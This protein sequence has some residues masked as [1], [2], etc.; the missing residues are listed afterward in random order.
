M[1]IWKEKKSLLVGLGDDKKRSFVKRKTAIILP[2]DAGE[3]HSDFTEELQPS[4]LQMT[5]FSSLL[6]QKGA[7]IF[8][9]K[10]PVCGQKTSKC[11]PLPGRGP[12][13]PGPAY[14]ENP[15]PG[16]RL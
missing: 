16:A 8:Q 4:D 9:I 13:M 5:I 12:P 6:Q 1:V 14:G 2:R 15:R 7:P 11:P 3:Y 10:Y